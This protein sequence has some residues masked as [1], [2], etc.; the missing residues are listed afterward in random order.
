[1]S[2]VRLLF[3]LALLL[4]A[5]DE[6]VP[7]PGDELLGSYSFVATRT[8]DAGCPRM[9]EFDPPSFSFS[10]TVTRCLPDSSAPACAGGEG[11][12][13]FSREGVNRD[14]GFDGQ[15]LEV[16]PI[17]VPVRFTR[18]GTERTRLV[19][20]MRVALLSASQAAAVGQPFEC[21]ANPLDGGVPPPDA[22]VRLPGPTPDGFDAPFACGELTDTVINDDYDG[23]AGVCRF[24]G[25]VALPEGRCTV[26]Y[27]LRG[28][29]L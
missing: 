28:H 25:G 9:P 11:R 7:L 29:R 3:G 22:G 6:P 19:D 15:Y 1:M 13:F 27:Q 10:G 16:F 17:E 8:A 2:G 20:G 4:A 24:D 26:V 18:C 5:C 23:G 14:A 12:V 21:P